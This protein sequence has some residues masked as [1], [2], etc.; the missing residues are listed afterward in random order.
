MDERLTIVL[1]LRGRDAF[2]YRW[3][4][5][6]NRQACPFRILIADG[7]KH[8]STKEI[9][10]GPSA[11]PNLEY[12][13]FRYPFDETLAI[14]YAK[15]CDILTKVETPYV[16]VMA[17]DDFLFTDGTVKSL[18]FLDDNPDYVC[19]RGKIIQ[20]LVRA[21]SKSPA[22]RQIYGGL[23]PFRDA[24]WDQ[25]SLTSADP[26]ERLQLQCSHYCSLVHDVHR[27]EQ[28]RRRYDLLKEFCPS[29]LIFQDQV[30][31]LLS[32]VDGKVHR[33]NW[34]YMLQ[35]G[36]T[37]TKTSRESEAHSPTRFD[38]VQKPYWPR[39]FEA[40]TALVAGRV[41]KERGMSVEE[42][43]FEFK[44]AYIG[45][46]MGPRMVKEVEIVRSSSFR[47]GEI[48]ESERVGSA[49]GVIAFA[50][51]MNDL[52]R[53]LLSEFPSD[54]LRISRFLDDEPSDALAERLSHGN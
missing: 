33:G 46:Y 4:D 44:K 18:D 42:A 43:S 15:I 16:L 25:P 54:I 50:K 38:W 20:F 35:Q 53:T 36:N 21:T 28:S 5:Y 31:D 37:P 12:S 52:R 6:M 48:Q 3:M 29:D 13:Y 9:L 7:G 22:F 11:F 34:L 2:T 1:L 17:N 8:D 41:A 47:P 24:Y 27:I 40:F 45:H 39:E 14:Y 19:A 51:R 32:A 10:G 23:I 26:L 30:K 49:G